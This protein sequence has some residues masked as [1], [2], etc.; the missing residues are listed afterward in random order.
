MH[1]GRR[2]YG[3]SGAA[4]DDRRYGASKPPVID[5]TVVMPVPRQAQPH[6]DMD[7]WGEHLAATS[8]GLRRSAWWA[9]AV[10]GAVM[11]V[12]GLIGIGSPAL[13]TDELQTWGMSVTSWSQMWPVLKWVDAVLA[14][15]YVLTW[16]WTHLAGDSDVAL[17][18]P[19]VAAMA[20]AAALVGAIGS[21]LVGPRA[22]LFAG[23]VLA[24]LPAASRFGQEA[25][26]YAL[27][28]FAATLA[29]YVLIRVVEKPSWERLAGY[30]ISVALAGMMHEIAILLLAGH[31]WY[32]L[33]FHRRAFG[34]WL[35]GAVVGTLPLIPIFWLGLAQRNQVAY[36][37]SVGFYTFQPFTRV[38]LG[39]AAVAV[40][41]AVLALFALPLR[42]P[43][44]LFTAWAL[45]PTGL[46]VL[47]S[48]AVPMFL[49]RY[50]VFT[51]PAWALLAGRSIARLRTAWATTILAGI[52]ALGISMQVAIRQA[53]GHEEQ[54]T[55]GA[56]AIISANAA[57][58]DGVVYASSEPGGGW[59]TRDLVAHYVPADR[60]PKDLL[61]TRPPR[62]DGQLLAQECTAVV[63]CLGSPGRIWV[64]RLGAYPDPL[65]GMGATKQRALRDGYRV[66]RVW[67][68]GQMTVAL[69]VPDRTGR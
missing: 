11:L 31:A 12:I 17:R 16:S 68:P 21:R 26:P 60:R 23:L 44:A 61:M 50:L 10:P 54:D 64:V 62:T 13:W 32:V 15:Y 5:A 39:G 40:A 6:H 48:L 30:A 66:E 33:A 34:R 37:Q 56:A 35:V 25:R 3:Q 43:A 67:R 29:P 65:A 42:R 8:T 14:P 41:V 69:L 38:V 18:L 58:G 57:P 19:S 49:P 24:A 28:T 36:I 59:T 51:L 63:R 47:V 27:A 4:A 46:L 22:G 9:W 7:P 45:V 55:R 1:H 2:N 52:L 20:G 53:D